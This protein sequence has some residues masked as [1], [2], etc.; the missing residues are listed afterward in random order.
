M[1]DKIDYSEIEGW[2]EVII[3]E[4][5]TRNNTVYPPLDEILKNRELYNKELLGEKYE[6]YTNYASY[7]ANLVDVLFDFIIFYRANP[8]YE[9][10][11]GDNNYIYAALRHH[12]ELNKRNFPAFQQPEKAIRRSWILNVEEQEELVRKY[13]LLQ[14]ELSENSMSLPSFNKLVSD[15]LVM[16]FVKIFKGWHGIEVESLTADAGDLK[17]IKQDIPPAPPKKPLSEI[18]IKNRLKL[19]AAENKA[20]EQIERKEIDVE[21][22]ISNVDALID[23]LIEEYELNKHFKA[24]FFSASPA[25]DLKKELNDFKF[26]NYTSYKFLVNILKEVFSRFGATLTTKYVDKNFNKAFNTIRESHEKL[27]QPEKVLLMD[28]VVGSPVVAVVGFAYK[29]YLDDQEI[30]QKI[31]EKVYNTDVKV[32]GQRITKNSKEYEIITELN[33]GKLKLS[34]NES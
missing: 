16:F 14:E 19:I 17:C 10:R 30:V 31:L 2:N 15:S 22:L 1:T 6:K 3:P 7:V 9:D 18:N 34:D 33:E 5:F 27:G 12:K 25:A 21:T 28:V 13:T 26:N 29:E 4:S 23:T 24:F 20:E 32:L 11:E 8:E